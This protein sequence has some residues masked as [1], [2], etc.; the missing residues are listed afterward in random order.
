LKKCFCSKSL[1]Q[2]QKTRAIGSI[3]IVS[4]VSN[5]TLKQHNI[6]GDILGYMPV[7]NEIKL[8]GAL[9]VGLLSSKYHD[10]DHISVLGANTTIDF[11]KTYKKAG[12]RLGLGAQLAI[13]ENIGTRLMARYQKGNKVVKNMTSLAL[14]LFYEF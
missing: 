6:Y 5:L 11:K 9:G 13:S 12:M 8:V 7:S 1:R 4:D 10:N 14:G 2:N 3:G